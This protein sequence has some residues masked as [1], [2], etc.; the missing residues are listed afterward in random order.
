MASNRFRFDGLADLRAD[1]RKLPEEL[2]DDASQIVI[3]AADGAASDIVEDYP[4]RTG[5]LKK[6]V[7]VQRLTGSR[8]FAGAIVR[9]T[10]KHAFLWENGTQARHTELGAN[11]GAMPPGNVFVPNVLRRRRQMYDQLKALI[12]SKGLTVTGDA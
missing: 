8:F 4:E 2:R 10:A 1:L 9:N 5:K 3:D 11:R 6:G 7:K 12:A